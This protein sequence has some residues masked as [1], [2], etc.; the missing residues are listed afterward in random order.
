MRPRVIY[1]SRAQVFRA[2]LGYGTCL[3]VHAGNRLTSV[4]NLGRVYEQGWWSLRVEM[5]SWRVRRGDRVLIGG[6]DDRDSID[7]V[8]G[9]LRGRIVR[10]TQ[11][12]ATG[13]CTTILD[14]QFVIE[15]VVD[16]AQ[17]EE[18]WVLCTSP[19]RMHTI[20]PRRPI[21]ATSEDKG[22]GRARP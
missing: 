5:A 1:G 10:E 20:R 8:L 4:D 3:L 11:V 19:A 7:P 15:V 14:H 13:D 2:Q 21:T 16:S 18:P 12:S 17:V 9:Q 22:K 6:M